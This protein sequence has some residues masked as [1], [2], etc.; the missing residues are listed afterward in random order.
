M[1]EK[2]FLKQVLIPI[3]AFV[4]AISLVLVSGFWIIGKARGVVTGGEYGLV[5][6]EMNHGVYCVVQARGPIDRT[7]E[8]SC[9]A[10]GKEFDNP[11]EE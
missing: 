10:T 9:V 6:V 3:I 11:A 5:G 1:K 2:S 8:F 7:P 4:L